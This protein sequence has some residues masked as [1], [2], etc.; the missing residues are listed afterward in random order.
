MEKKERVDKECSQMKRGEVG[1]KG[2]RR[3]EEERKV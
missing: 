1:E 3:E 2:K